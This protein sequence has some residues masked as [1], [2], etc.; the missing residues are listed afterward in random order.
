MTT[1]VRAAGMR[2]TAELLRE[3]GLSM[4]ALLDE[5]GIPRAALA[6][7]ELR[8]SLPAICVLLERASERSGCGDLGL[9]IAERQ[10]IGILGPLAIAMQNASTIGDAMAVLS[11]YLHSHSTGIRMSIHA[12]S[13][14]KGDTSLRL[15]LI[16]PSWMPRRQVTDQCMADLYHFLVW[17][18][19]VQPLRL[20]VA[21]PHQPI[22]PA[23]RYQQVFA[24]PVSFGE[25]HAQISVPSAVLDNE[26]VGGESSLHQLSLDYLRL[27]FRPGNHSVSE[28]VAD[29]LQRALS[30]TRGRREVVA[31][32]L[33]LHPRTLQRRLEA[34]DQQFSRILDAVRREQASRW[35]IESTIPL[36][37][38]ADIL[39]M[40]D[41]SVLY[42]CCERWFG[43]SP[44]QI[45]RLGLPG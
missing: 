40:A 31:K 14:K 15:N 45:R 27:V 36:A 33:G 29:I 1:F 4:E 10:D 5:V 8:I 13:P 34:E 23:K 26:L 41:Q 24:R 44:S 43:R 7:E 22:A 42:R 18:P 16:T 28:Q 32:L 2:G 3:L 9:R 17:L 19:K 30:S 20:D 39:G 37:H 25:P 38:I 11:R 12:D 35:L 6:D 21:L